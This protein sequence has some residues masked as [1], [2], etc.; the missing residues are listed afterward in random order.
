MQNDPAY[1]P[2]KYVLINLCKAVD[3][4]VNGTD[5]E[6]L[7]TYV[8]QLLLDNGDNLDPVIA[9]CEQLLEQAKVTYGKT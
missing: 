5:P 8:D 3:K 1:I 9:C 7:K 4:I 6:W 2:K